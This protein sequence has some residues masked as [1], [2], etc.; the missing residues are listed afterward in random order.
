MPAGTEDD[1]TEFW[2]EKV[3]TGG[4]LPPVS[5]AFVGCTWCGGGACSAADLQDDPEHPWD[6]QL[7]KHVLSE[8]SEVIQSTSVSAFKGTATNTQIWDIYK[9]ALSQK[10]QSGIPI[11]GASVDRRTFEYVNQ[12]YNDRT[13]RTLMCFCCPTKKVDTGRLRSKIQFLSVIWLLNLGPETIVKNCSMARYT[14]RFRKSGTPLAQRESATNSLGVAGP[15]YS[16]WQVRFAPE[17]IDE[18][19]KLQGDNITSVDATSYKALEHEVLLCN[20]EDHYCEHGCVE[21]KHLCLQCYIPICVDCMLCLQRKQEIPAGFTND[22]WYGYI[23]KWIFE[24]KVTWMEK[25]VSSPYWTGMTLF[26]ISRHGN[27]PSA[28]H[29]MTDV[30][31]QQDA[32]VFF[33]GQIFSAPMDWA[34]IMEQMQKLEEKETR[35]V[36]PIT[37]QVLSARVHLLIS[38]GLIELNKY[39]REITVRRD[40]VVRLIQMHRDSGDE[41]YKH[42]DMKEV[43]S[44]ACE[45]AKTDEPTIPNG[46]AEI[47]EDDMGD[48]FA[49]TEMDKAATPAE[50]LFSHEDLQRNLSRTRPQILLPERDSDAN[51]NVAASRCSA[52]SN[53]STLTL[54][55]GSN[56][57]DQFQSHY[58]PQVFNISLP[59]CVGGPDLDKRPRY[60]RALVDDAPIFSLDAFTATLPC[61]VE[62]QIVWD[63]E[64]L[65]GVWSYR[66]ASQ[67][68]LGTSLAIKRALQKGQQDESQ[69]E[70][71]GKATSRIY[72]LLAKGKYKEPGSGKLLPINGDLSKLSSCTEITP[73]Q[74]ALLRNYMFMSGKLAGTRQIRREINHLTFSAQVVYGLPVFLTFTPSERHSGRT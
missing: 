35:I 36:L 66:F 1:T 63:S 68:N 4:R 11:A 14:E 52:F 40:I 24:Q 34:D 42:L 72:A 57:I 74:Q 3:K 33:K 43:R 17:A 64:L 21:Q 56:L 32:R 70:S 49:D 22:N 73:T 55:T 61:R 12:I 59:W 62:S 67:V 9:L 23:E 39:I 44:K 16:D 58:F 15:D 27:R 47:L 65:P 51:K 41:R 20:P 29:K 19:L 6:Q 13:I 50:R 45:L 30:L 60:R 26:S 48:E 2:I 18:F 5:C 8:H 7:R 69:N 37:G 46:L 25:L 28:R 54:K 71:I 31:Y 38:S 53:V 10:E